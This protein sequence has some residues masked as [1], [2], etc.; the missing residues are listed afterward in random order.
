MRRRLEGRVVNPDA[1]PS[2]GGLPV[3][4]S[5]GFRSRRG[6]GTGL[7]S[8]EC[9]KDLWVGAEASVFRVRGASR[10]A[11]QGSGRRPVPQRRVLRTE[12]GE[13]LPGFRELPTLRPNLISHG[14]K[15]S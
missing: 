1:C 8:F 13:S 7:L 6:G 4:E 5:T 15:T 9:M 14:K 12:D 10:P 3:A 2:K 11:A